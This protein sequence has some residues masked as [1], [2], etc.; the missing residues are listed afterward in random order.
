MH[1]VGRL[2]HSV[3]VLPRR[4]ADSSAV[5]GSQLSDNRD[6]VAKGLSRDGRRGLGLP[7]PLLLR[8]PTQRL[9]GRAAS[10]TVA[11]VMEGNR[12]MWAHCGV[13]RTGQRWVPVR[14]I[15]R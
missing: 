5:A 9:A 14:P 6:S 4:R 8:G 7:G 10:A 2:R 15:Y 1:D 11:R 12:Q 3:N 13:D